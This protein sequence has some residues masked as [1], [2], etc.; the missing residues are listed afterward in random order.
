M[1]GM[2]T[3][4]QRETDC[5]SICYSYETSL[6]FCGII[7]VHG[8]DIIIKQNEYDKLH[9]LTEIEIRELKFITKKK[10]VE[11]NYPDKAMYAI[12]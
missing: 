7:L 6:G 8:H 11:Q 1:I 2:Y 9:I 5:S 3:I 12:G 10:I 4:F